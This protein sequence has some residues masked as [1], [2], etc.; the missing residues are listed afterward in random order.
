M[1]EPVQ[2]QIIDKVE[3][4]DEGWK[5][6]ITAMVFVIAVCIIVSVLIYK[7]GYLTAQVSCLIKAEGK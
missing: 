2:Q 6:L 4:S 5:G 1:S 3:E 7:Q